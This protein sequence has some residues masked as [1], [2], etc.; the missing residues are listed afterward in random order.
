MLKIKMLTDKDTGDKWDADSKE[1]NNF[2]AAGLLLLI[3]EVEEEENETKTLASSSKRR[4]P[5]IMRPFGFRS[6]PYIFLLALPK[7][8]MLCV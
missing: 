7:G 1:D 4:I 6:K 2:T 3:T 5:G 8:C